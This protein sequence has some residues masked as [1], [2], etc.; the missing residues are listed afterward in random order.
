M[1]KK[2]NPDTG[3]EPPGTPGTNG[4]ARTPGNPSTL[5][6]TCPLRSFLGINQT[7]ALNLYFG[8]IAKLQKIKQKKKT[9]ETVMTTMTF[10]RS[11]LLH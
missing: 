8:A 9:P 1:V 2:W 6:S 11:G 7:T 10:R 4:T 5:R 3:R